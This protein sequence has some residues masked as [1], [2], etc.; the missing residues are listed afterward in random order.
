MYAIATYYGAY[1]NV[2]N[3]SERKVQVQ[4]LVAGV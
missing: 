4:R 3:A 2:V 1:Y